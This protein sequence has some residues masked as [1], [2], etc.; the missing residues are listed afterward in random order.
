MPLSL[1]SISSTVSSRV[2]TRITLWFTKHEHFTTEVECF[3]F[4]SKQPSETPKAVACYE[5]PR[6]R[7]SAIGETVPPLAA[8]LR[9]GGVAPEGIVL[10]GGDGGDEPTNLV[11][12]PVFARVLAV[13][14][15]HGD[16]DVGLRSRAVGAAKR[17]VFEERLVVAP[18][19][20][21]RL[22]AVATHVAGRGDGGRV[23][24]GFRG[25][26]DG[27]GHVSPELFW[28]D[29]EFTVVITL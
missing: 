21:P 6:A 24:D 5:V 7:T 29:T 11:G 14:L 13:V 22:A 26:N 1:E 8:V 16:V 12:V 4:A 10:L 9:D 20:D 27:G 18:Q 3:C 19:L 15:H 23:V 17:L 25:V 2:S 28:S